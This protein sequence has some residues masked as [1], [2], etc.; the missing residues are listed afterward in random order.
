MIK[1]NIKSLPH[2]K[3][4]FEGL[5]DQYFKRVIMLLNENIVSLKKQLEESQR[6][7]M[8]LQKK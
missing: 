1:V 8:E 7:I 2:G 4:P 5:A 3:I 6:A